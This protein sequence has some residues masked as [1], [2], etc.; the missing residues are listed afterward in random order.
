MCCTSETVND[1]WTPI[2]AGFDL[3]WQSV[4]SEPVQL[5][6]EPVFWLAGVCNSVILLLSPNYHRKYIDRKDVGISFDA[7]VGSSRVQRKALQI[8][9]CI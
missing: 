9:S 7:L 1:K 2:A 4:I 8:S 5:N 3:S 6:N